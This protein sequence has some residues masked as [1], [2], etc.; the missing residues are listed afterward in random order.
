MTTLLLPAIVGLAGFGLGWLVCWRQLTLAGN[1]HARLYRQIERAADAVQA[2]LYD[3][4]DT[5]RV[6]FSFDHKTRKVTF[7]I[8]EGPFDGHHDVH[9]D[10]IDWKA[11]RTS[12]RSLLVRFD[13]DPDFETKRLARESRR[14]L[15][16]AN[17]PVN[18]RQ[19]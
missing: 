12:P 18:Q 9:A 8:D 2:L 3:T 1:E 15:N 4:T 10:A 11:V 6:A 16:V 14:L 17:T 19:P 7:Y 5:E 13:Q